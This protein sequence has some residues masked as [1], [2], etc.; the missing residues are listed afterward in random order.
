MREPLS[1]EGEYSARDLD[2][3][4]TTYLPRYH[5]TTTNLKYLRLR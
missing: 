1:R 4:F 5:K 3:V 2:L